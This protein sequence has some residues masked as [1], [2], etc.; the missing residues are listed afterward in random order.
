M[1][2]FIMDTISVRALPVDSLVLAKASCK[3]IITK[4]VSQKSHREIGV[5]QLEA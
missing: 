4:T 3:P 2:I 1:F 5:L